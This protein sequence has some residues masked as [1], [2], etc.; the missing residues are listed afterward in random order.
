MTHAPSLGVLSIHRAVKQGG[1]SDLPVSSA[2]SVALLY[3][4]GVLLMRSTIGS[5]YD[6]KKM[7]SGWFVY[8]R[9]R[10]RTRYGTCK[11]GGG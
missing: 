3:F 7:V 6:A 10:T 4:E 5:A 1:S 9:R 11:E 8:A 2:D